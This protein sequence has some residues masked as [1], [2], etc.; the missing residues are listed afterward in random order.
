MEKGYERLK[1]RLT[2]HDSDMRI[3]LK[4]QLAL[5]RHGIDGNNIEDLKR[6]QDEIQNHLVDK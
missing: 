6:S 5:L 1:T 4:S 3:L 2:G